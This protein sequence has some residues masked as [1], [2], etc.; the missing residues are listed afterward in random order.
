MLEV[1]KHGIKERKTDPKPGACAND[2]EGLNAAVGEFHLVAE[3]PLDAWTRLD[4]AVPY[5]I[6]E[7]RVERR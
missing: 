2:V 7:V 6:Y 1:D 3:Q 4:A 5:K